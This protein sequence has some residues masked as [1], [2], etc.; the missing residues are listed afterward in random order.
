MKIFTDHCKTA[1]DQKVNFMITK[2]FEVLRKLSR[3]A[4]KSLEEKT[5]LYAMIQDLVDECQDDEFKG[6]ERSLNQL[7]WVVT[8]KI[9][10]V[11]GYYNKNLGP[12]NV[13]YDDILQETYAVFFSLI[14]KY[15]KER[16]SF[17]FY[18]QRMLPAYMS[19]Y[20]KK[21]VKAHAYP[22]DLY[23]QEAIPHYKYSEDGDEFDLFMGVALQNEYI[24]FIELKASKPSRSDTL[25]KVCYDHFLNGKSCNAIAQECGISYHAVYDTIRKLKRELREFINHSDLSDIYI[26]STGEVTEKL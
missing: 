11:A 9:L 7:T 26:T 2:D 15:D 21:V 6:K 24:N 16:A 18:I 19:V 4:R 14:K 8:P 20:A 22:L 12:Y 25:S 3:K 5:K 23:T 10:K 13:D 1:I 17:L